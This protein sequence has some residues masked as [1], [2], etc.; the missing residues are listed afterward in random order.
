MESI[1]DKKDLL[2]AFHSN[3]KTTDKSGSSNNVTD[4][5]IIGDDVDNESDINTSSGNEDNDY[6][7]EHDESENISDGETYPSDTFRFH[8]FIRR[9]IE[10]I[11]LVKT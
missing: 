7:G 10:G 1:L 8:S 9:S 6:Y 5:T 11:E 4:N 3:M 2:V